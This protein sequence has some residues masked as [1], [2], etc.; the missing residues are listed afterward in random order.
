METIEKINVRGSI[1]ALKV[2]E[3]IVLPRP[4]YKPSSIRSN[5][6]IVVSDMGWK[7]SVLVSEEFI[8][9]KRKS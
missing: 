9:I 5:A 1:K 6:N 4:D 8:T 3:E 2:G 7:I